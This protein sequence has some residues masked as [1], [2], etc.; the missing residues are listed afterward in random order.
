MNNSYLAEEFSDYKKIFK[1]LKKV[2]VNNGDYILGREVYNFEKNL[3]KRM[4]AK[5]AIKVANGTDAI[6]LTLKAL[7]I[8]KEDELVRISAE[9]EELGIKS[10]SE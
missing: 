7:N 5:F 2:I 9:N 4:N 3:A 6:I 8:G 1:K 10:V